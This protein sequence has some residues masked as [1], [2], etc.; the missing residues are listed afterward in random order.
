MNTIGVCNLDRERTDRL[1]M[2]NALGLSQSWNWRRSYA[3]AA[4]G[5]SDARPVETPG[6]RG[7][8][9]GDRDH[10]LNSTTASY[11]LTLLICNSTWRQISK[12]PAR[13]YRGPVALE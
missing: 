4:D 6:F 1:A 2:G 10:V 8:G 3:P 5:Q 12:A 11:L 7:C 9:N 13:R